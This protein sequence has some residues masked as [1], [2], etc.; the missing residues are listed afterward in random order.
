MRLAPVPVAYHTD[1][2]KGIEF[3]GLSS[4]T[5]HNGAE[6]EECCRLMANIIIALIHR[7]NNKDGKEVLVEVCDKFE[8]RVES[9]S[10]L[11]KG[12]K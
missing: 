3:S 4:R 1:L 2:S 8:S 12:K 9:V 10:Y 7:P 6:S 5:T 11:A